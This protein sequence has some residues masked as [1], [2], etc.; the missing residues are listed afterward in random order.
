MITIYPYENLGGAN[1]GWLDARHH[2]S[3]ARYYN[4]D[5]LGFGTLRVI[6]DDVVK[7][8]TG[9]DT[10]PHRDMEIITY[11][12]QGAITHRDSQNNEGRTG[13]GDVQVMS[14]GSG[15]Y[16]SEYNL[17]DEETNLY[18]IWIEPNKKGVPP[19]WEAQQFP[20]E[21][22]KDALTPLVSGRDEDLMQGAL[23]IHADAA[24]HGGRLS[25]G[26]AVTHR[27]VYQGYV[28][29]SQ[30][31]IV[32]NGKPMKKGDGAE[33]TGEQELVITATSDAEV[34]IIDI[35]ENIH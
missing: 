34:L 2:F 9:F 12:R 32:L 20:K 24:I 33:V 16:H 11:V 15:V 30:G 7:P 6:N 13:A 5:R 10:H 3:F 25:K 28:L 8:H 18:Q 29:A 22:V 4:P 1:H 23:F 26:T 14:A 27:L 17:E 21:P 19:R 35:P 31:D